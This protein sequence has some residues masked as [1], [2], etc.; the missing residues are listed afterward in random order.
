MKPVTN[1]VLFA[2]MSTVAVAQHHYEW[3]HYYGTAAVPVADNQVTV[4][5]GHHP[6]WDHY[7][8]DHYYGTVAV[9]P[10]NTPAQETV[11]Q[12]PAA[13]A[14]QPEVVVQTIEPEAVDA[15]PETVAPE[16]APEVAAPEP[17]TTTLTP[18]AAT[19]RKT[20]VERTPEPRSTKQE[21]TERRSSTEEAKSNYAYYTQVQDGKTHTFS[22]EIQT[23]N[24][25]V[26]QFAAVGGAFVAVAGLLL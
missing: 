18:G 24:E 16:P 1:S 20:T 22:V 7:Y 14:P 15:A 23:K 21:T 3:D 13:V 19:T 8:P 12:A 9:A 11:V 26:R 25:G 4:V 5:A 2:G 10:A 17:E 6:E